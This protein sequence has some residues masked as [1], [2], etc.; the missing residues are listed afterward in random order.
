MQESMSLKQIV[1]CILE[2]YKLYY[3]N[4]LAPWGDAVRASFAEMTAC[5]VRVPTEIIKQRA[6]AGSKYS[7]AMIAKRIH[8]TDGISGFYRGY[9]T[10]L[11]REI[12]FSFIEL[13]L[14]EF[15]KKYWAGYMGR[16]KC[17]PFESAV[18]GSIAGS[19]AAAAT[20]PLDVVKTR[21]MLYEG[22]NRPTVLSTFAKI[23]RNEGMGALF[24]GIVPRTL[25][26]G[27]GGY[28]FFFAYEFSLQ[29]TLKLF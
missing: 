28:V 11:T 8:K 3:K 29:T 15:M 10:T 9:A 1:W 4:F 16:D 23:Y 26:M 17:K 7:L 14:W 19:I 18:C 12:P 13:P 6:Q 2:P 22:I 27:I 24:S 25:W 5:L 20:T 21:V